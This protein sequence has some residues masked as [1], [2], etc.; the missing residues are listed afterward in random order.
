MLKLNELGSHFSY[1]QAYTR[2]TVLAAQQTSRVAIYFACIHFF[3][4][5]K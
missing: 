4:F 5:C 3:F 1:E 2:F